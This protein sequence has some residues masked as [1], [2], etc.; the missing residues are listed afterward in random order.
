MQTKIMK[1]MLELECDELA[2][3]KM[4]RDALERDRGSAGCY[5]PPERR[6]SL[7]NKILDHVSQPEVP[8]MHQIR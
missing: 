4:M 5:P 3:L 7:I 1:V 8:G 2:D 6:L